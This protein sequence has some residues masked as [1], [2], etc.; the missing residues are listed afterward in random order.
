VAF[1]PD[2][3]LLATASDDKTVRLWDPS[4]G[5]QLHTAGQND[6]V[7]GVAFSPDGRLAAGGVDTTVLLGEPASGHYLTAPTGHGGAIWSV[8]FSPDGLVLATASASADYTVRLWDLS[9]GR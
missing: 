4:T 9:T 6:A 5:Q 1:S 8:A 3:R 2:G 7:Y